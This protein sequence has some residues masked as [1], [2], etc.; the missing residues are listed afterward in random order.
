MAHVLQWLLR[1]QSYLQRIASRPAP[2]SLSEFQVLLELIRAPDWASRSTTT[3]QEMPG[4]HNGRD[5]TSYHPGLHFTPSQVNSTHQSSDA[6]L[7]L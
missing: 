3:I 2:V 5:I 6:H 1:R 7:C 4:H